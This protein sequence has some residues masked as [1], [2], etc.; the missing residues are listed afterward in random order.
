[1]TA[2]FARKT[3]SGGNWNA[4]GLQ[5]GPHDGYLQGRET[6]PDGEVGEPVDDDGETDS[7][8]TRTLREHLSH[9]H[10]RDRPWNRQKYVMQTV[11]KTWA[12][13]GVGVPNWQWRRRGL[14]QLLG[15]G[16][17]VS[18]AVL[19]GADRGTRLQRQAPRQDPFRPLC[20]C[21][22]ARGLRK[23]KRPFIEKYPWADQRKTCRAVILFFER[24]DA[25][26]EY[27]YRISN[28]K[29]NLSTL[30]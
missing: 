15:G 12:V 10:P 6:L 17:I 30:R 13:E 14:A 20:F 1:M 29:C 21:M 26:D 11:G 19:K 25:N 27:A 5:C 28:P 8:G 22:G 9:D 23:V 4:Q 7:G 18:R 24:T 3:N 2:K 16:V